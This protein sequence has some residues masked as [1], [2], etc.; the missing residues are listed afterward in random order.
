MRLQDRQSLGARHEFDLAAGYWKEPSYSANKPPRWLYR[1]IPEPSGLRAE[2]PAGG[3]FN[4]GAINTAQGDKA[5]VVFRLMPLIRQG[6]EDFVQDNGFEVHALFVFDGATPQGS[7]AEPFNFDPATGEMRFKGE[8]FEYIGCGLLGLNPRETELRITDGGAERSITYGA[9]IDALAADIMAAPAEQAPA[10][11]PVYDLTQQADLDRLKKMVAAAWAAAGSVKAKAVAAVADDADNDEDDEIVP[12]ASL[13]VPP[14]TDLLGIDPTVYRQINAALKSG[15]QHIMLYGPPGTGK[16]TLARWIAAT[17][18][19][20]KWTLVTGSSDWS[21]QDIIGGYQPVGAGG[22][23]FIPGVL[24]RRFD[25]PLIIDE[26]NRCDIDKVVGPLFT[27]L[28]GQQT[29]LP[30]LGGPG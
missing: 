17:L 8:A 6:P 21:S 19:G 13:E 24:L 9:V 3:P 22:V 5:G 2:N 10:P 27:V 4:L 28:S 26:L 16:T 30:R 11:M 18:T 25:R 20:G 12:P 29:D 15:K 1:I 14:N 23:A 7:S